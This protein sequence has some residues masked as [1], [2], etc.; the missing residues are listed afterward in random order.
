VTGPG[1]IAWPD[2]RAFAFAIFDDTDLVTVANTAPVYDFLDSIG[3][4][5]TKSVWAVTGDGTPAFGGATCDDPE[6]LAWTLD[7]QRR[8]HEIAS[9]G[10]TYTTS[11]REQTR[12]ALDRFRELYGH[13]PRSMA[14]HSGCAESIYWGSDRVSGRNRW[15][16]DFLTRYRRRGVFRGH[17]EGDPLFWGDLCKE[18]IRYVRNF[19][20]LET[21]TLAVCPEMPYHDP[22][23]PWVERWFAATEGRDADRFIDQ[24]SDENMAR[25]E[26]QGGACIMYTHFASRF[27]KNGVLDPRFTERMTRLAARNGWF[28]PVSAVLDHLEGENGPTTI[29]ARAR[30]RLERRWLTSKFRVGP[31]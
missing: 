24:V 9:H 12:R 1:R 15:L 30:D 20:Y 27:V 4:M 13:D 25:L 2:G 31:S 26:A 6:Y 29:S 28:A 7:L 18:R 8:G 21:N 17:V 19:T 14:N 10:A 16:Y 23:R 22:D 11:P 3:L 5:A